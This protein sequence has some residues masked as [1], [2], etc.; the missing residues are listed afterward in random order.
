VTDLLRWVC[1]DSRSREVVLEFRGS[2]RVES[3]RVG[4][5]LRKLYPVLSLYV[6]LSLVFEGRGGRDAW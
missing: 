5:L 2:L 6:I 4:D 1:G 3:S